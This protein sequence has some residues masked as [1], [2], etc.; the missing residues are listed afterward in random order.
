MKKQH[1]TLIVMA[2]AVATAALGSYGVYNAVLRMP[3]REVE[4][5]SVQVVVAAQPLQ[6]GTRLHPN[7]LRVVA[8]PSRNP[9]AGAFADPK[10]LVDR[11]V[12]QPIGEN[13]PITTSKV[14]SLEAGAGLPPVIPEGMRA[15]SVKVNEV[16]GVAGFVVPG[17]IVDVLVTVRATS[18]QDDPMTRT[19][20]SKV[21]VLTAGTKYD[22][23]KSK[24]GE[25]IPSSVVTLAVLPE[26]G[27]RITLAQNEGR[28]T[29]AL[30]NPLDIKATDT[31]GVK[32]ASLMKGAGPE[33]VIDRARNRVIKT[34]APPAPPPQP[35][36]TVE[37]IRAAKRGSEVVK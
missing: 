5:G 3:V 14:A 25:P 16:V 20:V 7:H 23:E 4:V 21:T 1:R 9:V 11:G 34:V 32:L 12:I 6:M 22:Q 26:D 17:T 13:E 8:W 28:I 37:T 30:R 31:K 33:P 35:I 27:E 36:Y 10:Q 18:G 29:L 24:A 2:V 15:I 19:V